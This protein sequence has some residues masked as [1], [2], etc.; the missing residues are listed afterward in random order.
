MNI[1]NKFIK[2]QYLSIQQKHTY[3]HTYTAIFPD[4]VDDD[5]IDFVDDI[6]R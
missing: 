6:V 4:D 1:K 5:E 3:T 2:I